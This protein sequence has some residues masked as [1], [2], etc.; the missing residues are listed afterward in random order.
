MNSL[1]WTTLVQ[2]LLSMDMVFSTYSYGGESG[3]EAFTV[4][5]ALSAP[6]IFTFLLVFS[7][8]RDGADDRHALLGTIAI[9]VHLSTVLL[10]VWWNRCDQK[11]RFRASTRALWFDTLAG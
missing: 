4:S 9:C 11:R 3:L 10:H 2:L 7:F 6:L 1:T 8:F 5:L